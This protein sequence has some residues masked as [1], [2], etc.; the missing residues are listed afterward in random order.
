MSGRLQSR[1]MSHHLSRRKPDRRSVPQFL[2]N[3]D[4][5]PIS[6][7]IKGRHPERRCFT[8]GAKNLALNTVL[9]KIPPPA[10]ENA[11]VRDDAAYHRRE[12]KP[13]SGVG[14]REDPPSRTNRGK[15]G[16]T[17]NDCSGCGTS[18]RFGGSR[19]SEPRAVHNP[20]AS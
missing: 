19:I 17:A 3:G 10:G 6:R 11:G 15:G 4:C 16:A 18:S 1:R 2:A 14:I 12:F 13:G 7:G 9:A 8:A 5:V 20:E